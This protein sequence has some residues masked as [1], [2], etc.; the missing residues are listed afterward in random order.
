MLKNNEPERITVKEGSSDDSNVEII[1][2]KL[3]DGDKIIIGS[4]KG[5][6]SGSKNSNSK[7]RGGPPGMF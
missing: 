7:R 4:S 5:A 6:K 2:D 3:K 1:S